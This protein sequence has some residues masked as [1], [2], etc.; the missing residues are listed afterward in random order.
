MVTSLAMAQAI[1]PLFFQFLNPT[2]SPNPIQP[3]ADAWNDAQ[4]NNPLYDDFETLATLTLAQEF[5]S[6]PLNLSTRPC[7]KVRK[8]HLMRHLI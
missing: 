6:D 1:T 7:A 3:F 5:Y 8:L 2:I 4:T